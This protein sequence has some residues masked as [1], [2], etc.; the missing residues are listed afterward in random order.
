MTKSIL[1]A[2]LLS[3]SLGGCGWYIRP[4]AAQVP[5]A[6]SVTDVDSL[7]AG[8]VPYCGP[9][10]SVAKQGYVLLPCPPGSNYPGAL[11]I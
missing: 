11:G 3:I 7:K 6:P 4:E 8:F 5:A 9:I 1:L 10:W 2:S